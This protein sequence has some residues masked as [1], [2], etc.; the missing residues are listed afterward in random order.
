MVYQIV[1]EQGPLNPGS[2]FEQYA[3][4]MD[5][6]RTQ[7]TVRKYLRKLTEYDLL[8]AEG[9]SQTREYSVVPGAPEPE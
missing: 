8:T 5:D 7:R 4:R 9:I 2:I 1:F 3:D 6:P